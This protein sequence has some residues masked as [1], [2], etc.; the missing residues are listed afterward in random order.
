M[1]KKILLCEE[2]NAKGRRL[3]EDNG[4]EIVVS[5]STDTNV[6]KALCQDVY[7]IIVRTSPLRKEVFED[8]ENLAIIS[9]HGIGVDNIDIE[10]ASEQGVLVSRV[11]NANTYSVAEYIVAAMMTMG[12]NL[13]PANSLIRTGKLSESGSSLPGLV[14]KYKAGGSEIKGKKLGIIGFGSIGSVISELVES[15]NIS[16]YVFD[17]FIT[18]NNPNITQVDSVED[19]YQHCDFITINVP[20]LDSTKN[21]VTEETFKL[22][23]PNAYLINA[24][25]GGIVNEEDLTQALNNDVI[26]GACVDVFSVE[27]P[28]LENPL[29][30]AKNVIL[31]PHIAGTTT[32]AIENLS[33]GAAQAIIDYSNGKMPEYTVNCELLK[34]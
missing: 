13:V 26:A 18:I 16:V 19:I 10:A 15:L 23:K 11:V 34:K 12:R 14:S 24:S 1:S 33:I 25:R 27:P 32:E 2:I 9:R 22:M 31:T 3:L 6:L 7:G 28:Q 17:K 30:N 29:F 4:F 20:L 5:P 21:M 8:A